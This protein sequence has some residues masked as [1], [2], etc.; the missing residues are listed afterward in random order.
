[1]G[2][3]VTVSS[4]GRIT[5]PSALRKRL[6]LKAGDILTLEDRGS[7]IVLKPN[8]AGH[9]SDEEIAVWDKADRLS[10]RERARI[11]ATL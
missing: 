10:D 1:M 5:L 3:T 2:E 4:R 6:D 8:V 9:Y 7:E 11:L